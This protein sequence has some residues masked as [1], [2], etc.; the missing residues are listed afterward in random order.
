MYMNS[1]NYSLSS[2]KINDSYIEIDELIA[3]AVQLLNKKGYITS[4]S[5]SGHFGNNCL[6]HVYISFRPGIELLS[7]PDGFEYEKK[8][9]QVFL[10]MMGKYDDPFSFIKDQLSYMEGLYDWALLLP[11]YHM[12]E[13]NKEIYDFFMM[14]D[15][16]TDT[17]N[18]FIRELNE[19]YR[20]HPSVLQRLK[21]VEGI[22]KLYNGLDRALYCSIRNLY[23]EGS[24]STIKDLKKIYKKTL[25]SKVDDICHKQ[26][27]ACKCPDIAFNIFYHEIYR[28]YSYKREK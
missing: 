25:A 5:C 24:I 26:S 8:Y 16:R 13:K 19:W 7:I 2:I 27:P 1:K 15:P 10:F 21:N 23:F 12:S 9:N 20:R 11:E 18:L 14:I 4:Y 6:R 22:N 3:P 17:D 28:S